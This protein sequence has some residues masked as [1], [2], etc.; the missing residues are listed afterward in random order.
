MSHTGKLIQ[1]VGQ[2]FGWSIHFF[3]VDAEK[4]SG[5]FQEEGREDT[6]LL[7]EDTDVGCWAVEVYVGLLKSKI[8]VSNDRSPATLNGTK[9]G[10]EAASKFALNELQN[11][12]EQEYQKKPVEGL[13]EAMK[14][15]FHG[16]P[17]V[18]SSNKTW[19]K[20]IWNSNPKPSVVGID[21]EGN[22]GSP[23][24][25]V[26]IATNHVVILEIPSSN[27]NGQ[28]SPNLQ[29]LL[30]DESIVKVFCENG[31]KRDMKSLGLTIPQNVELAGP[32]VDLED[33]AAKLMGP[34]TTKRGVAK[35]VGHAMPELGIRITKSKSVKSKFKDIGKYIAI[36]QNRHPP[37]RG[38]YDLTRR[39]QLYAALDAWC[40][41]QAW[42][43]LD[44]YSKNRPSG[45]ISTNHEVLRQSGSNLRVSAPSFSP[46]H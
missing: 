5:Q 30:Q 9:K 28:L 15:Q 1:N 46:C 43:R 34:T 36:E 29:R 16:I 12:I 6:C 21:T 3:V 17:I 19:N 18:E 20:Y 42:V 41:L 4:C 39:E 25:L 13:H 11:D 10:K 33:I 44:E 14:D 23:P 8:F 32:I 7:F 31:S 26:Q 2:A 35:I 27:K 45:G 22:T 38:I 40:T 37:L 24:I